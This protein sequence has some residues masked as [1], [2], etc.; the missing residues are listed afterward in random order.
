VF[1]QEFLF[2][3]NVAITH[4]KQGS[5]LQFYD[6]ES[7]A[8]FSKILAIIFKFTLF[9]ISQIEIWS[10]QFENLQP[11]PPKKSLDRKM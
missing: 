8:K 9:K 11:P 1:F 4:R 2:V 6:F 10:P 3:A 7:F 5:F